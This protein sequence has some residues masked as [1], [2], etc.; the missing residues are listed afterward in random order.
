MRLRNAVD[1][2]DRLLVSP[3]RQAPHSA[4]PP[5]EIEAADLHSHVQRRAGDGE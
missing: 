2:I 3:A 1:G 5:D 4:P